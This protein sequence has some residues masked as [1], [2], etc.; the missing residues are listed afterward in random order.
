MNNLWYEISSSLVQKPRYSQELSA[1]TKVTRRRRG[2][3]IPAD[4]NMPNRVILQGLDLE[5]IRSCS[6]AF[7][8]PGLTGSL[9]WLCSS[10][11][12]V[13]CFDRAGQGCFRSVCGDRVD[14]ESHSR[15]IT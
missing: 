9:S 12:D 5:P 13:S 10:L 6:M 4:V 1:R 8:K 11:V 14:E 15:S 2:W 3:N 7:S